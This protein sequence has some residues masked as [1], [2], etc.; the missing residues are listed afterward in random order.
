MKRNENG[1]KQ[2]EN[3]ENE[4]DDT[5]EENLL[6]EVGQPTTENRSWSHKP[7]LNRNLLA[8]FMPLKKNDKLVPFNPELER[9]LRVARNTLQL[10]MVY[11]ILAVNKNVPDIYPQNISG[12]WGPPPPFPYE[13]TPQNEPAPGK[14]N[15]EEFMAKFISTTDNWMDIIEAAQRNQEASIRNL[16]KQKGQLV[17]IISERT[18]RNTHKK[19]RS[20][21]ERA[22]NGISMNVDEE[23]TIER[24][25]MIIQERDC[26]AEETSI[27][28]DEASKKL[29]EKENHLVP[30]M[31]A[32]LMKWML[33]R[34]IKKKKPKKYSTFCG[35]GGAIDASKRSN[36]YTP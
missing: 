9:T 17:N 3:D 4:A 2:S 28:K 21:L 6:P 19:H 34:H 16:E 27:K 30:K 18:V 14:A 15:L 8:M 29:K 26:S 23:I 20:E 22:V 35:S 7:S 10:E 31:N 13:A 1:Q 33:V 24:K 5:H 32:S 12:L 11:L 36:F 25:H